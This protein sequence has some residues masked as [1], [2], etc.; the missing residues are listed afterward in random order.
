LVGIFSCVAVLLS[1]LGLLGLATFTA[2]QREKEIATR[3]ILGASVGHIIGRLSGEFLRLVVIA[4]L[5][6]I[7][8][9]WWATHKW[10]EGF[11]YRTGISW[12]MFLFAGCLAFGVA[13]F[14]VA[15]QAFKAAVANPVKSLRSQ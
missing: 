14:T 15:V 6:A 1:C 3:K 5:I 4:L 10:L 9:G 12:W 7:P 13:F 8:I 2:R 11:S